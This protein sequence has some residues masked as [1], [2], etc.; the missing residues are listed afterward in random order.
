MKNPFKSSL[1][2][3]A[4][5][6]SVYAAYALMSPANSDAMTDNSAQAQHGLETATFAGGCFWCME[7]PFEALDGVVAVVSGYSGGHKENPTY[8]EVSAG[9]TGH[10]EVVRISYDPTKVSYKKLLDVFWRQ[11]DP[12]DPGG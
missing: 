7:H 8:K 10:A 2:I 1:S 9:T 4:I 11:I 5:T 12:T 3:I 6:L